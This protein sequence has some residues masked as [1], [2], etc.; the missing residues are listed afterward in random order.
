M[1]LAHRLIFV[2]H[3]ETDWN[4][5]R[6]L[7]G[8]RDIPLNALG[9]KQAVAA[10]QTVGR[11]VGAAAVRPTL[12]YVA[13]PLERARQTMELL[14]ATL[15]LPPQAYATDSR[16]MELSFGRWEGLTWPEVKA[17]EPELAGGREIHKWSFMPPGGESYAMLAMRITP[18]LAAIGGDTLVVSHGGVARALLVLIGGMSQERAPLVDI[19][20]GR[21][22][23][24]ESGR[25]EWI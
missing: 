16:L 10:G 3:G 23:V 17:L 13:S 1:R 6:R 9:R 14:R 18:W 8:Q 20:Q 11:I 19:W 21:L 12:T 7:Q 15:H 24:F 5:E 25:F 2:R 4:V 22:L